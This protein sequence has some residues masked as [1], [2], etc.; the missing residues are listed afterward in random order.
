[1]NDGRG[2]GRAWGWSVGPGEGAAAPAIS[3]PYFLSR[4]PSP[5][6]TRPF[7]PAPQVGK[8]YATRAS[9][10]TTKRD[11]LALKEE[12]FERLQAV[13]ERGSPAGA[14]DACRSFLARALYA[15]KKQ[16]KER[17]NP[18]APHD[19]CILQWMS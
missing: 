15:S 9:R 5:A 12:G 6:H 10:A 4:S 11:A 8:A 19:F 7:V 14:L 17:K 2:Y 1:M 18:P 13:F 3:P 16:E